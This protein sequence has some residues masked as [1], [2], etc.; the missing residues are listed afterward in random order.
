MHLGRLRASGGWRCYAQARFEI[1]DQ[2]VAVAQLDLGEFEALFERLSQQ[3]G[4]L[5]NSMQT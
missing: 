3:Q 2:Q 1:F 5:D 4:M